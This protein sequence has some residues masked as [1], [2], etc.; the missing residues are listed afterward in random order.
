MPEILDF[1][2]QNKI[3]LIEDCAQ[4]LGAEINSKKVGTFGDFSCFSFHAQK[5]MS[6][7]GEGG[8][9]VVNN[10]KNKYV[11]R[12]KH[13]GHEP[14]ESQKNYWEPAMVNVV[15]PYKEIWPFNFPLTEIQAAVGWKYLDRIDEQNN[16]RKKEHFI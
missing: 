13:N 5:N 6:T 3:L 7:L 10:H 12:L 1:C 2:F 14:F 11:N 15:K 16:L 8:M 4:A 9:L